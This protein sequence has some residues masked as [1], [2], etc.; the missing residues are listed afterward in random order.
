MIAL[1]NKYKVFGFKIKLILTSNLAAAT[2]FVYYADT[3]TTAPTT[4]K[5]AVEKTYATNIVLSTEN[6]KKISK[7]YFQIKKVF[8]KKLYDDD[9]AGAD[10]SSPAKQAYLH[11]VS[12]HS[13]GVSNINLYY[14]MHITYYTKQYDRKKV[15]TS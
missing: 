2:N 10:S 12:I 6:D 14:Q 11:L 8:G 3:V 13:D 9:Y 15:A 5:E 1:Y 7:R 4:L